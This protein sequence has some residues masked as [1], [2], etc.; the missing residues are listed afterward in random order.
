MFDGISP[1]L[2]FGQLLLG[3]INGSFYA[4]L[5]MGL[6]I[7]FGLMNVVNFAHGAQ[8]MLGAFVAWLALTEFGVPYWGAL[9]IAPIL[10]AMFG[11]V[12]ERLLLRPLQNLDHLYGLLATYAV[13]L[14]VEGFITRKYGSTGLP[15]DN[16][17]P[18]GVRLGFMFL[19]AYRLWVVAF[20]L[21]VCIG[22]WF[23]IEHTRLG[24]YLRAANERPYMVEAF[25][26]NVPRMVT[27]T[28]GFGVGLAALS[29][30]LAAP[31]YQV[32]PSMGSSVLIVV[33][34]VVVI[35][36]MGSI[37][38]A[39]FSGYALGL[40][41]GLTKVFYPSAANVVIF[42]FMAVALFLRPAGLF[43]GR[44]GAR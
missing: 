31:I 15:Y 37:A 14:I 42:L 6:A 26:I 10:V 43:A 22:T 16:P 33:F 28:Y 39:I 25:G 40:V 5:S 3:L 35:G 4:M 36:G 38:G 13:A 34:A 1:Q 41:E 44:E 24:A 8:Y 23:A 19:P 9:V 12:L 11:M 30:V 2:L 29:G 20:S 32:S 18:Y 7:I 27:L 21:V 17:M